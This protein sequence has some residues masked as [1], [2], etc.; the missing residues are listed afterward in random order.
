MMALRLWLW[1][2][3]QWAVTASVTEATGSLGHESRRRCRRTVR[4]RAVKALQC[5]AAQGHSVTL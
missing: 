5:A 2:Q 1:R 3:Y 4:R